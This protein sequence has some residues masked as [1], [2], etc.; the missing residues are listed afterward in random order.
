MELRDIREGIV[1]IR[2]E[3]GEIDYVPISAILCAVPTKNVQHEPTLVRVLNYVVCSTLLRVPATPLLFEDEAYMVIPVK[4]AQD[5][6]TYQCES[7]HKDEFEKTVLHC[8]ISR[9]C[10]HI[11][12]CN[13]D[14]IPSPTVTQLQDIAQQKYSILFLDGFEIGIGSVIAAFW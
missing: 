11:T 8:S 14:L 10:V 4:V 5:L 7:G 1:Y 2:F 6:K 12:I 3:N 13:D 9:D